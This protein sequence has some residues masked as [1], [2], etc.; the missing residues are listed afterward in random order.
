[1]AAG[2]RFLSHVARANGIFPIQRLLQQPFGYARLSFRLSPRCGSHVGHQSANPPIAVPLISWVGK[3][4]LNKNAE[5]RCVR[6]KQILTVP[7]PR[8]RA[9]AKIARRVR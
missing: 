7:E 2:M 9:S 4:L 6:R 8:T 5:Y 3:S 1:M